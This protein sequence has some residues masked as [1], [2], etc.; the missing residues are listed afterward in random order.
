VWV[1][2]G[3]AAAGFGVASRLAAIAWIALAGCA[4]LE[5]LGPLLDLPQ[6]V[7]DVSP[8]A[9][10]PSLPGGSADAPALVVLTAIAAAL[11]AAGLA[12]FARR[13]VSSG[14]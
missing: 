11:V 5:I 13:D 12:A 14:A 2:A 8:F 4:L 3:I 7:M 10:S 6:A 1:L 9:H